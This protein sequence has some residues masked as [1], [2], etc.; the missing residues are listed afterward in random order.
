MS[1]SDWEPPVFDPIRYCVMTTVGLIA[2]AF[3]APFAVM[4]MSG[5]GL[6]AYVAAYRKGLRT[7]KCLLRDP[8]LVMLYLGLAFVG[9]TA[10][11]V[12]AVTR[13]FR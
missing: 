5:L 13:Y 4:M 8:L 11:T 10:F 12:A 6:C 3:S 7:T 9:G 2:W 1:T